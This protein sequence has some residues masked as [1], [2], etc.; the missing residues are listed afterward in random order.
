MVMSPDNV[1]FDNIKF[2]E[3]LNV[4]IVTY[5]YIKLY[6]ICYTLYYIM[7]HVIYFWSVVCRSY[8]I[9]YILM[10]TVSVTGTLVGGLLD[11]LENKLPYNVWVPYDYSSMLSYWLTYA[12]ETVAYILATIINVAAETSV[13][14]FCLQMCAQFEILEHRLQS[15]NP[16]QHTSKCFLAD[17]PNKPGRLSEHICHHLCIIRFI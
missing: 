6:Y 11:V 10:C 5:T 12:Q 3:L 15:I 9:R 4:H 16:T 7:L 2:P 13:L 14:G 8:S 17:T 1:I